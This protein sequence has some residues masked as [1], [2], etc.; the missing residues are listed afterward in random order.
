MTDSVLVHACLCGCRSRV[1]TPLSP[2][3][4]KMTNDGDTIS[5]SPSIGNWSFACQSHYWIDRNRIRWAHHMRADEIQAG[6][7]RDRRKKQAYYAEDDRP[8]GDVDISESPRA[9]RWL[10]RLLRRG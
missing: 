6:R 1:G 9:V 7:D 3:D 2:T 5:L 10:T 8:A 4:W